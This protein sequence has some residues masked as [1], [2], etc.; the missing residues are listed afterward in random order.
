MQAF[1]TLADEAGIENE[2]S[3]SFHDRGEAG[4]RTSV[5]RVSVELEIVGV[6][7]KW[8]VTLRPPL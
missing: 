3:R 4:E 5:K 6:A 1:R 8:R 7:F 2:R